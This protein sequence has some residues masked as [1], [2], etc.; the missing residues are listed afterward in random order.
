MFNLISAL[1]ARPR[2][3][4]GEMHILDVRPASKYMKGHL[5]GAVHVDDEKFRGPVS[6]M[7]VAYLPVEEMR[8]IFVSAGVTIAKPALVYADSEDP[9]AATMVAYCLIKSGHPNALLLN[10]GF[11]SWCGNERVTREFTAYQTQPWRDDKASDGLTATLEDVCGMVEKREGAII[12]FRPPRLFRGEGCDWMRNGHIPGA[13][14]IHWKQ[15]MH[16]DNNALFKP[17]KEIEAMLKEKGVT[18]DQPVAL[19]CGTGREAT[20]GFLYL[21]GV[22]GW[23]GAKI[24][25]GS[26]TEWSAHP[27]LAVETGPEEGE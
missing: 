17:R 26:W 24:C 12:D 10:G 23:P 11:D 1:Q 16:E 25:E 18:K 6:G 9:L 15:F 27:E 5:P 19:Y 4:T 8:R 22:L 2:V 7:P 3:E 13:V 14:N 20:L 21:R